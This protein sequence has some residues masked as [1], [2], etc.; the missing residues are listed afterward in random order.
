MPGGIGILTVQ[1]L[2]TVRA[3]RG[4]PPVLPLRH[5]RPV[6]RD[7]DQGAIEWASTSLD[8]AHGRRTCSERRVRAEGVIAEAKGFHGLRRAHGRGLEKVGIQ[9][10]LIASVQN[11]KR[12]LAAVGDTVSSWRTSQWVNRLNVQ[13]MA[14]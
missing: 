10:L 11:L 14:A 6:I 7:P 8:R 1:G 2:G 4:G 12:R 9:A 5:S 13:Q 3:V